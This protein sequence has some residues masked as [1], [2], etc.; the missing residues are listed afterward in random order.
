MNGVKICNGFVNEPVI[1]DGLLCELLVS[2][3]FI[4]PVGEKELDDML[5]N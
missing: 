3:G 5:H 1:R 4:T 2:E